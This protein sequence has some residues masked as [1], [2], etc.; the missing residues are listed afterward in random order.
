MYRSSWYRINTTLFNCL[1]TYLFSTFMYII[2]SLF[3]LFNSFLSIFI[4][5]YVNNNVH[6]STLWIFRVYIGSTAFLLQVRLFLLFSSPPVFSGVRVTRYLV[7]WECF[8]G[9]CMTFCPFSFGHCVVC[10]SSIYGF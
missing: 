2:S 4:Q 5:F 9:R 10:S 8:V 1:F 3:P 6:V 7:L